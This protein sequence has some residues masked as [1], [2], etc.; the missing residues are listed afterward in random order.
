MS[1][2]IKYVFA[3]CNIM[4]HYDDVIIKLI[5]ESISTAILITRYQLNV[6]GQWKFTA[7]DYQLKFTLQI[8][9][10]S[11]ITCSYYFFFSFIASNYEFYYK[12]LSFCFCVLFI[13]G[14]CQL[15]KLVHAKRSIRVKSVYFVHM[16]SSLTTARIHDYVSEL[17]E[18][19]KNISIS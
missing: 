15:Q 5:S 17:T 3:Q 16:K 7:K 12:I 19:Q 8:M 6:A 13:A 4:Q 2:L 1:T 9:S 10:A 18:L 14:D 11:N